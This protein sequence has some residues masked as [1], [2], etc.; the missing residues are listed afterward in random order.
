[1]AADL[2]FEIGA[3]LDKLDK[4]LGEV[5]RKF[6]ASN[7]KLQSQSRQTSGKMNQAFT[8]SLEGIGAAMLATFSVSA[9]I[10]FQKRVI[11]ITAE[12]QRLDAVL[13]TTLGSDSA[14]EGAFAM[15]TKFASETPFQVREITD[16]FVR[17]A[18]QGFVPTRNEL[19]TLGDLAASTGKRFDQLAEA[20]IDAQVGEFERLKEFG[21]RAEKQ[22]DQVTFTFKGVQTQVEFTQEAIRDYITSLGDLEGVSGSM[23]SISETLGGKI[24]NLGDSFDQL[25]A[26]IGNAE[27]GPLGEMITVLGEL[28]DITTAGV[29]AGGL[30]SRSEMQQ[31]QESAEV[32][33]QRTI[34]KLPELIKKY[35]DLE[36]VIER[37]NHQ[38]ES[39]AKQEDAAGTASQ[40]YQLQQLQEAYKSVVLELQQMIKAEE[41]V[42]QVRSRGRAA[43]I[44]APSAGTA[45]V[46]GAI[47]GAGDMAAGALISPDDFAEAEQAARQYEQAFIT[48]R[49]RLD[50]LTH[51]GN[52]TTEV[53]GQGFTDAFQQ[54]ILGLDSFGQAF[55]QFIISLVSRL[56]SAAAAA[57]ILSVILSSLGVG[58]F[59]LS[60]GAGFM[61]MFKSGFNELGGIP[62]FAEGGMVTGPT[63]AMV[64]DNPSGKEA[65][66]PFEKMGQFMGMA[67]GNLRVTPGQLRLQGDTLQTSI[68]V[69]RER[70]Q[71]WRNGG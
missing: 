47:T 29:E 35:G 6:D 17:L 53:L 67:G 49:E 60:Q 22:G 12:F 16:S 63:L 44:S 57:A 27:K 10:N 25:F 21:I 42:A 55:E 54:M 33:A 38:I 39:Y 24:S 20:I 32:F 61:D 5:N 9:I 68:G 3:K 26:A 31:M 65:I 23:A 62:M 66:I 19:R 59:G 28:V 69:S 15:I 13:K 70:N 43:I 37:V 50:E 2:N 40:R 71:R 46:P 58:G 45:A 30:I 64:G 1:M 48:I 11:D 52:L 4:A 7:R 36:T 34:D 41:Q 51:Y 14:A 8:K 56:L 18:N